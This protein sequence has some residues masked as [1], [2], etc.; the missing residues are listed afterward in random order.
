MGHPGSPVV[1]RNSTNGSHVAEEPG[2]APAQHTGVLEARGST[3][4]QILSGVWKATGEHQCNRRLLVLVEHFSTGDQ[5]T[6][7]SEWQQN[8]VGDQQVIYE[9][10]EKHWTQDRTLR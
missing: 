8:S 7:D 4:K 5:R 6:G 10:I 3:T 9:D 1:G 2:A